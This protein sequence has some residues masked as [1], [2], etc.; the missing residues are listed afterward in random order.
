MDPAMRFPK[1]QTNDDEIAALAKK[2][3]IRE[4]SLFGSVLRDDFNSGSD[5]DMLVV[6][7]RGVDYSYFDLVDIKRAFAQL[8]GRD[9][10]LVEREA[11]KNP[12]RRNNILS[13]A[14]VVYAA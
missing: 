8:F 10:D 11:I 9:V 5:I 12:F 14:Q 7:E 1:Y 13:T 6:F 2:Y 4:L 3:H